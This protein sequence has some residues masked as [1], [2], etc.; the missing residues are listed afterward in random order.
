MRLNRTVLLS[1][2]IIAVFTAKLAGQTAVIPAEAKNKTAPFLFTP[3]TVKSGEQIYQTNCKSCHGDP[4]KGNY[5]KLVPIPKDPATAEYQKNTDGDMFYILSNG[6]GLMPNFSN[7]LNEE[8]RW[9]VISFI[10][11]LN[12]EYKQPPVKLEGENVKTETARLALGFDATKN[13]IFA[14]VTDS[15][16]GVKK[17]LANVSIKLFVKRYF[18]NLA[19][20]T[21]TTNEAGVANFDIP[22]DI[23]GDSLGNLFIIAKTIGNS[24][25][26]NSSITEKLGVITIPKQLLNERTWWNISKMAPIW[27]IILYSSGVLTVGG[28]ILYILLQLRKIKIKSRS[29]T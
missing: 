19:I 1:I 14:T 9:Q 28:I 27:L 3:E 10:R 18:G 16:S 7:I 25:E 20:A 29:S 24:K 12:K 15:V 5:A 23:P 13:K 8:Q 4:G 6:R 17:P 11:S 2:L 22:S 21:A 26:L